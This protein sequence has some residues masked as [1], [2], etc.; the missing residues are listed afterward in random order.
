ML[1]PESP[2]PASSSSCSDGLQDSTGFVAPDWDTFIPHSRRHKYTVTSRVRSHGNVFIGRSLAATVCPGS[3]IPNFH[4]PCHSTNAAKLKDC[5]SRV[6]TVSPLHSRI[7]L[8]WVCKDWT[9]NLKECSCFPN[10]FSCA[11]LVTKKR[12]LASPQCFQYYWHLG[13]DAI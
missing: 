1:L 5:P 13:R 9:W 11:T 7:L 2:R 12:Q 8:I 6:G 10:T 3:T 4:L